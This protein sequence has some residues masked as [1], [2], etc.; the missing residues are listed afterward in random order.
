MRRMG[1]GAAALGPSHPGRRKF[2]PSGPDRAQHLPGY[3]PVRNIC[4]ASRAK[5][6]AAYGDCLWPS[7]FR[8]QTGAVYGRS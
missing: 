8:L 3:R 4:A 2:P 6:V 7:G 1:Q 5:A